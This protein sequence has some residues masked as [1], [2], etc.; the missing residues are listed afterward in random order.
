MTLA[1]AAAVL[2]R[3]YFPITV[4][5]M[6][7]IPADA[8]GDLRLALCR[9]FVL[10]NPKYLEA[11][12]HERSTR[13][14]AQNLSYLEE[15]PDGT[16]SLPRGA[17]PTVERICREHGHHPRWVDRTHL[18]PPVTFPELVTLSAAQE[19][20]VG[21]LLGAEVGVL[22]A[23]AGAGKTVM[24]LVAIARRQQPALWIVHTKELAHQAI[25]RAGMVLGLTPAEIGFIGGGR[26][27]IGERL[28]VAIVQSLSRSIPA[29]LL[30]VGHVVVDECHH[31]PAET[32]ASIVRQF[33]ARY[34]TGLTATAFRRDGLDAVIHFY[35]GPTAARITSDEL[36]ERLITP[37]YWRRDTGIKLWGDSFTRL[38][39]S[40]VTRDDRNAMIC[41]DVL[42]EVQRGRR[43]LVLTDRTAHTDVLADSLNA[44][45]VSTAP[46]H[47]QK[48]KRNRA[49]IVA[50]LGAGELSCVVATGSLVGEG[51]DYP[52]FSALF[53]TTPASYAGRI[54]QYVG[55]VKRTAPGKVDAIVYDYCDDHPMLWAGWRKRKAVYVKEG[56]QWGRPQAA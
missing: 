14:L 8:P 3:P 33:P 28:T 17:R 27:T 56:M 39:S 46:L 45:G 50:A 19:R 2:P 54:I 12:E 5:P 51:F 29:D 49:S 6:L 44:L 7:T 35:L 42:A 30:G 32:V 23:P 18:A 22:E 34:L 4:G 55:R 53:L 10:P 11:L 47:G 20:A 1:K 24:G 37:R 36:A 16:V 40:L 38:V 41:R 31:A 15:N 43:C 21:H 13:H 52:P 25:A 26:C 48:S 9:P